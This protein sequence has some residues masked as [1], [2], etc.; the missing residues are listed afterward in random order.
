MRKFLLCFAFLLPACALAEPRRAAIPTETICVELTTFTKV[1]ILPD[2][3]TFVPAGAAARG[4]KDCRY[5]VTA[6]AMDESLD[7]HQLPYS[8]VPQY[9][10]GWNYDGEWFFPQFSELFPPNHPLSKQAAAG[11]DIRIYVYLIRVVEQNGELV[12]KS[13]GWEQGWVNTKTWKA[14]Q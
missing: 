7:E 1:V 12:Y 8:S 4:F 3:S 2:G 13:N 10:T 6:S 14:G 5:W 11:K 9:D